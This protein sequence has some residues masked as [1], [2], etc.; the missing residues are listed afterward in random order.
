MAD[1]VTR[2]T[3]E[4]L[5]AAA[6]LALVIGPSAAAADAKYESQVRVHRS[7]ENRQST[8]APDTQSPPAQRGEKNQ[9]KDDQ[10]F[11]CFFAPASAKPSEVKPVGSTSLVPLPPIELD[12]LRHYDV[13][14]GAAPLDRPATLHRLPLQAQ[15]PPRA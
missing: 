12:S 6:L 13:I 9:S 10:S 8:G 4:C 1:S 2:R 5:P 11:E 3:R 15:A 14:T 7:E